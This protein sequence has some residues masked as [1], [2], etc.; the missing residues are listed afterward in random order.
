METCKRM[1]TTKKKWGSSKKVVQ[2]VTRNTFVV[3]VQH[4]QNVK[5]KI[6]R[7]QRAQLT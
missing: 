5:Y 2:N 6:Q 1:P 4:V 7:C 3:C